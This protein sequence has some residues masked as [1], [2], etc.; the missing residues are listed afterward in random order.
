MKKLIAVMVLGILIGTTSLFAFGIG[1][2]VGPT[3]G[4]GGVYN[5]NLALTFKLDK[6]PWVFALDGHLWTGGA[7][8]ALSADQWFINK[9]IAGPFNFF[10]G[11]GLYVGL[12]THGNLAFGGRLPLGVNAFFIDG[13]LEP[14]FQIVPA[15]G[16]TLFDLHFPDW[17]IAGNLGLRLWF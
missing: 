10:L 2:Q 17:G 14:Y 4:Q 12:A 16:I 13:F 1:F 11:W 6:T 8:I 5:T 3:V 15:A 7:R 9:K